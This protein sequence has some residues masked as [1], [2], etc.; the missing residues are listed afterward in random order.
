MRKIILYILLLFVSCTSNKDAN[1]DDVILLTLENAKNDDYS[2]LDRIEIVP[3]ETNDSVLIA[4]YDSFQYIPELGDYLLSDNSRTVFLF[5]GDG[6]HISNSFH[7]IGKGPKEYIQITNA[8]YNPYD[9]RIEIYSAGNRG[10]I[11]CYDLNFNY[12]ETLKLN[13]QPKFAAS[14]IQIVSEDTYLLEPS[15]INENSNYFYKKTLVENIENKINIPDNYVAALN[16]QQNPYTKTAT[17]QYYSPRYLDYYIYK[18]DNQ[19]SNVYPIYKLE[20][21]NDENIREYLNDTFGKGISNNDRKKMSNVNVIAKKVDYLLSSSYYLPIN[22]LI[23]DS[24]IYIHIVKNKKSFYYI[25]NR[26]T[27]ENNFLTDKSMLPLSPCYQLFGNILMSIVDAYEIE[28][29]INEDTMMFLSEEEKEKLKNI[30]EDDNPVVIKYI[31][32]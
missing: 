14:V 27:N 12:I 24:Y 21:E 3:L 19:L 1:D 28:K 4:N 16:M 23:S 26:Q 9:N 6:A 5:S 29:Y 7:C 30:N 2:F 10:L 20:I 25:H 17:A 15:H 18:F 11:Y 22:K 8:L 32:K 31:L 13:C